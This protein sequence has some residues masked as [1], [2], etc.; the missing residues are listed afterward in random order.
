MRVSA[1]ASSDEGKAQNSMSQTP[2]PDYADDPEYSAFVNEMRKFCHCEVDSPCDSVLAAGPCEGQTE[3]LDE[4]D[5]E[6]W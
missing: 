5:G 3:S 6:D 2:S 4:Y 1:L